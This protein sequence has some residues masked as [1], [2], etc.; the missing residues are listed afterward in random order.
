MVDLLLGQLEIRPR[1]VAAFA[2]A[3]RRELA[4]VPAPEA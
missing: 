4:L 2:L 1:I 3:R